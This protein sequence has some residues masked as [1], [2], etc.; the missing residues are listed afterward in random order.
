[1]LQ[2]CVVTFLEKDG[3]F[4]VEKEYMKVEKSGLRKRCCFEN[5]GEGRE[6]FD[7]LEAAFL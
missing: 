4:V 3:F 7:G 2:G 5:K 1:M 6:V